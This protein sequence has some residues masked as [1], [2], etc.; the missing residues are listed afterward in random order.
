MNLDAHALSRKCIFEVFANVAEVDEPAEV[1]EPEET[2]DQEDVVGGTAQNA[3]TLLL[4]SRMF[5][6]IIRYTVEPDRSEEMEAYARSWIAL[7]RKYGGTHHG[8]FVPPRETD[9][10]PRA[11]FSFPGLGVDAPPNVAY[12]LFSFPSVEAY[13]RYRRDVK[14]DPECEA[15]TARFNERPW[16]SRYERTF[17]TPIFDASTPS[18]AS[19]D[20]RR[21]T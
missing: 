21:D 2:R 11:T 16:F 10:V 5:T 7:I 17:A 20:T 9:E 3:T 6:C 15:A 14:A 8:Y 12:A 18:S 4:S 1:H 19:R 13:E